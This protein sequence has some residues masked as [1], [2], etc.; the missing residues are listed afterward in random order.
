MS[1]PKLEVSRQGATINVLLMLREHLPNRH[2]ELL[3]EIAANERRTSELRAEVS[4]IEKHAAVE[5]ISLA[6]SDEATKQPESS[7]RLTGSEG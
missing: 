7:V 1:A 2:R 6:H 5:G 4:R 3:S